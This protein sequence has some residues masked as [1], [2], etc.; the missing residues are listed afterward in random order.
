MK[1]TLS[2][3]KAA[4]FFS[5]L[6]PTLVLVS[7]WCAYEQGVTGSLFYDDHSN[8]SALSDI[9]TK[10]DAKVF[11]FDGSSG[12]LGRPI[13]LATFLPHAED[14]PASHIDARRINVIIHLG[15]GILLG[16]LAY[17]ILRLYDRKDNLTSYYTA[18]YAA[19]MWLALPIL[20]ST[21]LILIQRMTGLAALFGLLGLLAYCLGYRLLSSRPTVATALQIGGLG[22]ATILATLTKENGILIPIFAL[23]IETTI[24]SQSTLTQPMRRL[25][26]VV[27][28]SIFGIVAGYLLYLLLIN[29]GSVD[30]RRGF[31]V[32]ERMLTQAIILWKYL[33][34]A[35]IPQL[36]AYGPYHD[37]VSINDGL[38][39]PIF[40]ILVFLA[41][42]VATFRVRKRH[43]LLL[44]A[45]LWFLAG[46]LLESTTVMLEL[47][48]EHRNYLSTFGICLALSYYAFRIPK[49]YLRLSIT[50]LSLYVVSLWTVLFFLA[51]IW[52][53]PLEAAVHWY[54]NH[55]TS[56]R[57]AIALGGLYYEEMSGN[58]KLSRE[59][60]DKTAESCPKCLDV[61][62][63]A[64]LYACGTERPTEIAQRLEELVKAAP[65]GK[66]SAALLDG[67]YPLRDFVIEDK[68]RPIDLGN[69]QRL[70]Q[71][72]KNNPAS[73]L[74]GY[75]VHLNYLAAL[76]A[77]DLGKM[78]SAK[79][80]LSESLDLTP[81]LVA[82]RLLVKILIQEK[83]WTEAAHLLKQARDPDHIA[84]V[85]K[86]YW[87][88][89]VQE[90]VAHLEHQ[91]LLESIEAKNSSSSAK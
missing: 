11:L 51:S 29:I 66:F 77:S 37:D 72:V 33:Y 26:L 79:R 80:H 71:A 61:R 3:Y 7:V 1:P 81:T 32:D 48:F 17:V 65:S 49:R 58:S 82:I 57:A 38:G 78:D 31:S 25:R 34:L 30:P 42:L 53:K 43:P 85:N 83:R 18:C 59:I 10:E 19:A 88:Q 63:Q 16:F 90:I 41:L 20:A 12:P 36:N 86:S 54:A 73:Y 76:N 22:L 60:L 50:A 56:T 89:Q 87:N 8:L 91:Q 55:P 15:N 67:I 64:L 13:A 70:L 35:F 40:A 68:C 62:M 24:G 39:V 44:L 52:G 27:L 4:G 23:I 21:N 28:S 69:I 75:P 14:W 5:I 6:L 9:K 74:G 47:Y 84:S 2:P 46:H 45:L